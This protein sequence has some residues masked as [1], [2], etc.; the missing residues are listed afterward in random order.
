MKGFLFSGPFPESTGHS[1]PR[2][3]QERKVFEKTWRPS[4]LR[5]SISAKIL[6]LSA[7]GII[8]AACSLAGDVTPPPGFE[9]SNANAPADINPVPTSA[10]PIAPDSGLGYP[11]FTPS[12][13]EGAFLYAQNCT[14][15]HGAGGAGDGELASQIQFPL[16]DL[17]TPDLARATTPANWFS[18]ITDGNIDR[19]MPPWREKL[20]ETERWNLVA[21]LYSLS[22]PQIETGRQTYAASCANC[23][24]ENGQ[25]DGKDAAAPI[26]DFTDQKYMASKSDDDFYAAITQ[27]LNGAHAYADT[28][29]DDE[30]WA[31]S[32]LVRSFSFDTTA[33]AVSSGTV[34]GTLTNGT[35]GASA[36]DG[37]AVVLHLFDN[38]QETDAITTTTQ[39][40]GAFSFADVAF[41]PGRALILSIDYGGVV[42]VSDVVSPSSGQTTYD[43]PVRVFE[44]T[45]DPSA[46][47]V[48]RMHVIFDFQNDL[49]QVAELFIIGNNG[50]ATFAAPHSGAPTV[51]FALPA[52][53]G[54]L[55]FQDGAIGDRYLQTADGFADTEPIRPG[56]SSQQILVSFTLPY[57]DALTFAQKI[58]YPTTD[59]TILLPDNGVALSGSGI[60]DQ[61]VR[62]VQG[63]KYHTY[64]AAG[65][66]ANDVFAFDLK[67]QPSLS[68]L[69]QTAAAHAAAVTFDARS[70]IVGGIALALAVAL[71]VYW[72][73]QRRQISVG[74]VVN[75][76]SRDTGDDRDRLLDQIAALD[77]R[78][79]A[80]G[81]SE[82]EYRARREKLKGRLKKL[83]HHRDTENTEKE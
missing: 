81:I 22:A 65:L 35:P 51:S 17:T 77:D 75:R 60:G 50:D 57:T 74:A 38:F 47:G 37:Q 19:V 66:R 55:A 25:G 71:V 62:D 83:V 79:E 21:Y 58:S 52:G 31:V 18:I 48:D 39:S 56:Q 16:P 72:Q 45:S 32:D 4:R 1:A 9:S 6:A 63:A 43:L 67:G 28:L 29:T 12:V 59:V 10:P 23:H 73:M 42:Y 44:S 53:Y 14:R 20:T 15:C 36:P 49:V 27:G 69:P 33:L 46:I 61:G 3:R 68:A 41:P 5:G 8:L 7:A 78:F 24:G 34:T 70:A 30:R 64:S 40:G 11:S 76:G 2:R 82:S 13:A 26:P 80:G 54:D